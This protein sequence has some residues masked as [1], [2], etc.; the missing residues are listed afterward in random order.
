MSEDNVFYEIT[1]DPADPMAPLDPSQCPECADKI[2][3][4]IYA[5]LGY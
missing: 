1:G 3:D 2:L 5:R 4:F